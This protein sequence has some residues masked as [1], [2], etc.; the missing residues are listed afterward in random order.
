MAY[1]IVESLAAQKD[2]DHILGYL[3]DDLGNSKAALDF[4]AR[5]KNCYSNLKKMP[6]MYGFC[7]K[8]RLR[9]LGYRMAVLKNYVLIYR[10]DEEAKEVLVTRFFHGRQ[11]YEK[12]L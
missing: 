1:K 9:L 5:V 8:K 7:H 3:S 2:L 6:M 4:F 10:V 12:L 11:N